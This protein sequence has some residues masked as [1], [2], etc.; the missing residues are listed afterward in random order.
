M[1]HSHLNCQSG[2]IT[3]KVNAT[4]RIT[5]DQRG[6]NGAN[7]PRGT[8]RTAAYA[9]GGPF[10]LTNADRRNQNEAARASGNKCTFSS[11]NA[12]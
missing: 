9:D 8:K 1:L 2:A 5:A 4:T 7:G 11:V 6:A 3:Y 10:F 12:A